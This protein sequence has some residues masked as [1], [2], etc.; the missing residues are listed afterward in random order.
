[1]QQRLS[2]FG[3]S[4]MFSTDLH[5][6]CLLSLRRDISDRIVRYRLPDNFQQDR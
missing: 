3:Q 6:D 4:V 1:M 5:H 2:V